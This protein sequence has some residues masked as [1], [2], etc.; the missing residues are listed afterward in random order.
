[1]QKA[2]LS[3]AGIPLDIIEAPEPE[4]QASSV[5][6]RVLASHVLSFTDKVMGGL[7]FPIPTPYTP[8]PSAIGV[9]E[10]ISE[11][12]TGLKPGQKVFCSSL[13][14]ARNNTPFPERILKGWFGITEN[15]QSLLH[16]WKEGAFAEQSVY[17]LECVT[18]IDLPHNYDDGRLACLNYLC[19]AY[20]ALLRGEFKPGQT[21]LING[22][23]G[24]LGSATV[25]MALA[26]GAAKVYAA[27]RNISVLNSVGG[28]SPKRIEPILLPE[29]ANEYQAAI[30]SKVNN[31][32][33]MIDATG[34][35]DN[36]MLVEAGISVL[37]PRGTAVFVGGVSAEVRLPYLSLLVKELNI[38]G[39][40]MYP[41][42]APAEILK[43][44]R[45]GL[46]DLNIFTPHMYPLHQIN[47]AIAQAPY[48][49][50]FI[51]TIL[52]P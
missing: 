42:S 49:K 39:S 12:I 19:I 31:V 10:E 23:T 37:R 20:G 44:V 33:A 11:E 3:K 29:K 14:S 1:M 8:G 22:A 38:K 6:V 28:I 7:F 50:G 15:C 9:V 34:S 17:P 18:P 25:L 26:M 32:D 24:N 43:M 51:Y 16:Q 48:N 40:F 27:G 47:E 13:I 35:M 46:L 41:A 21:V 45:S 52:Q 5:R 30:S 4:L 2:F 36:A